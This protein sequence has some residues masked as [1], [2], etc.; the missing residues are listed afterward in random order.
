MKEHFPFGSAYVESLQTS[1]ELALRLD[2]ERWALPRHEDFRQRTSGVATIGPRRRRMRWWLSRQRLLLRLAGGFSMVPVISMALIWV[3]TTFVF[4]VYSLV[5]PLTMMRHCAVD[6]SWKDTYDD[7]QDDDTNDGIASRS[8]PLFVLPCVLTSGYVMCLLLMLCLAPLVVRFQLVRA[9]LRD[10]RGLPEPF[11]QPGV[12]K[13]LYARY[14]AARGRHDITNY[15]SSHVG[16]Y[17][18]MAVLAF[19]DQGQSQVPYI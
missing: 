3:P 13:H 19:L 6:S 9:D 18:S 5:F 16:K 10:I 4:A 14:K 17:N 2:D 15:L 8:K 12:V 7:D 11:Y 1:V